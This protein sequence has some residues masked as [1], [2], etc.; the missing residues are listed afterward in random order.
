ML[1]KISIENFYSIKDKQVLDLAV[2]S[3]APDLPCF[4]INKEISATRIPKVVSI[5]G[6]NASGKTTVLRALGFLKWFLI[7]SFNQPQANNLPLLPF[8]DSEGQHGVSRFEVEFDGD[9][10]ER[11]KPCIYR[12]SLEIRH[13]P[14]NIS[15]LNPEPKPVVESESLYFAP[16]GKFRRLFHCEGEQIKDST[17]FKVKVKDYPLQTF[18]DNASVIP[19]L[20]Q[21]NHA[22]SKVFSSMLSNIYTNV[23]TLQK[24]DF[25]VNT[26]IN[27]YA[28][29]HEELKKLNSKIRI[30]D[31]GI[32]QVFMRPNNN[33]GNALM[34]Y[35]RHSGLNDELALIVES[36]GTQKFFTLFPYINYVLEAGGLLVLDEIDNDIHP[37]LMP[38]IIGWFHDERTNLHNA[39]L[40]MACHNASLLEHLPKEEI[41]FTEK[42]PDGRTQVYGLKDI[43]GV[44]RVDN[45]YK[46]YLGGVFGAVP[47]IG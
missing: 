34:P 13:D 47:N 16:E 42:S 44:R 30:L 5:F 21:Y 23:Y 27:Y 39:Q 12:Y 37:T 6:A 35:F 18:R 36:Q 20:I 14:G 40:I 45:Y 8:A 38:E 24:Y 33:P 4:A 2:P 41:Y 29:N 7:D 17:E 22:V 1:R 15:P 19:T 11:E 43:T 25:D 31:L 46:K 26:A 9:L 32:E 28:S 3:N 10:I